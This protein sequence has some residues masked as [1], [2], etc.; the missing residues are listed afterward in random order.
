MSQQTN[1]VTKPEVSAVGVR[2][3]DV[4][5]FEAFT[6]TSE[7]RVK[8]IKPSRTLLVMFRGADEFH[9]NVNLHADDVLSIKTS[10]PGHHCPPMMRPRSRRSILN[11]TSYGA[12]MLFNRAG[13]TST[14]D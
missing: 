10:R 11:Q 14:A 13:K 8:A 3:S 7:V 5:S 6:E 1:L 2:S 4:Q 9:G 12:A